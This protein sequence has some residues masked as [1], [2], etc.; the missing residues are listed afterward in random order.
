MYLIGVDFWVSFSI[1]SGMLLRPV[2]L[3]LFREEMI[4]S[5]SALDKGVKGKET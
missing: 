3:L 4:A 1:L 2:D 5:I